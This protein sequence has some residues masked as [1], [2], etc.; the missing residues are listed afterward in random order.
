MKM[1]KLFWVYDW[2]VSFLFLDQQ[3]KW[4]HD[5]QYNGTLYCW[6]RYA[7]CVYTECRSAKV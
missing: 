5:N 3:G 2:I 1:K 6:Y 7:V 4:R